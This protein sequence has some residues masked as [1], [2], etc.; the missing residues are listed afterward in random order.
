M[1]AISDR[2]AA[3][4]GS[5]I[6]PRPFALTLAAVFSLDTV[7][8]L[9]VIG[10]GNHYLIN[11]LDS[12]SSYP[13]YALG[14]HGVVKLAAA[15]PGGWL[16]E[17]LRAGRVIALA[18]VCSVGGLLEVLATASAGGY[19]AGVALLSLG[20]ALAWL[21]VFNVVGAGHEASE[22]G[23]AMASMGLVSITATGA[24][25]ALAALVGGTSYWELA[26]LGGAVLSVGTT[27]LLLSGGPARGTETPGTDPETVGSATGLGRKRVVAAMVIFA[28]F[29]LVSALLAAA[30]P[31]ALRTLHLSLLET[32]VAILPAGLV[33]AGAM[34]LFGRTSQAGRRLPVAALL[35]AT[36]AA[37]LVALGVVGGPLYFGLA[38]IPLAAGLGGVTPIVN[39]S[40]VDA[41]H[42]GEHSGV[43]LGYLFFAE[44]LGSIAGPLIVGAV[45]SIVD[46][47]GGVMTAA[48]VAVL[49]AAL[50]GAGSK[51]VDL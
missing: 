33:G 7:T 16:I 30:A 12:P 41:S 40:L 24:G 44:G 4:R 38:A 22:R 47:R 6:P 42:S 20:S 37:A 18:G 28:H 3:V 25:L 13:A 45:I 35:Y 27:A 46:V 1:T 36:A 26:F 32:G 43:A 8:A 14:I 2:V 51:A 10:Y 49:L 34:L 5:W 39:A 31:L 48:G 19:F 9:V 17:R 11:V 50:A 21:H 23:G 15:P 29:A